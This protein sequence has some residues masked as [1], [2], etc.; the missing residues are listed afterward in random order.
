M[1]L[2]SVLVGYFCF[3]LSLCTYFSLYMLPCLVVKKMWESK[4]N[5][6]VHCIVFLVFLTIGIWKNEGLRI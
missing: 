5:Y 3:V 6:T 4:A 1:W 2:L